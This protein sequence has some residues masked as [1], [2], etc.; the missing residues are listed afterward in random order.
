MFAYHVISHT[1]TDG[2]RQILSELWRVL[3]PGGEAYFS[4]CSKET[5]SFRDA[6]YPRLDENTVVK[7]SPGPE[8]GVPHFYVTL[9]E[10]LELLSGFEVERV[11]HVDDCYFDGRRQNSRHYFVLARRGK[12]P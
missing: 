8:N 3:R 10:A 2:A 12:R 4:L 7:T 9:E 1:D 5:W 11:R 6:G